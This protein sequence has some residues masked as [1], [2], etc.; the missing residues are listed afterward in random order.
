MA[1]VFRG[2]AKIS[3]DARGRFAMPAR[4]REGFQESA[5]RLVVTIDVANPCLL[6]YPQQDYEA[7]EQKLRTLDNTQDAIRSL[8]RKLIGFAT[9]AEL[10]GNGRILV[11]GELRDY[12][13]VDR[14]AV[15]LGQI[16]KVE[17][18]GQTQWREAVNGWRHAESGAGLD[19]LAGIQL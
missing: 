19:E 5:G 2:V 6:I 15:L 4:Y 1:G 14:K 18:W 3:L 7:L 12:A 10:D 11:P 8:Q 13:D 16:N 17:L 9:E